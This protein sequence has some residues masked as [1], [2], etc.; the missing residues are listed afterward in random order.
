MKMHIQ[1]PGGLTVSAEFHG[2][3]IAT[4]QSVDHGGLGAAPEPFDLFLASIGTCAGIYALRFCRQRGID[5]GGLG[6]TLST[7]PDLERKRLREIHLELRLPEGFP[8]KYQAA[9]LRAIDQCAVKRHLIEPPSFVVAAVPAALSSPARPASMA[10][11]Y[12]H[13][14]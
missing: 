13:A 14:R 1:F 3:T 10:G 12:E 2:Y 4:D 9:I 8:E 5:T 7:V 6:L 11:G